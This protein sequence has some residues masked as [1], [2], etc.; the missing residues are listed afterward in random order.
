VTPEMEMVAGLGDEAAVAAFV[1]E[2]LL[3]G[4]GLG[5]LRSDCYPVDA[6]LRVH[7]ELAG[8]VLAGRLEGGVAACLTD[9]EPFVRS[10][11]LVFFRVR[12][13]P[14]GL[15]RIRELVAGDRQ[16]FRGVPDPLQP[17]TD[18]EQQLLAVA[19]AG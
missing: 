7:G 3:G 9:P 14:A 6:V 4:G 19:S 17:G 12:R 11:A 15:R 5:A 8:S 18:L 16:L 2:N 13:C 1:R 10:Q